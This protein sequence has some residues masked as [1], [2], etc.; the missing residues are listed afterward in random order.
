MFGLVAYIIVFLIMESPYLLRPCLVLPVVLSIVGLSLVAGVL[1]PFIDNWGHF[2][3]L[4]FGFF[5]SWIVVQYKPFDE[6][7]VKLYEKSVKTKTVLDDI[8][9]KQKRTKKLKCC[10]MGISIPL[11]LILFV[12]CLT[13]FYAGQDNW[14]G[15]TYFNCIPYTETFCVDYGQTLKSRNSY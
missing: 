3:G 13:W 14:F 1:F 10:M 9:T 12:I 5:L 15:F 4:M 6:E 7:I 11:S 2:G 8:K